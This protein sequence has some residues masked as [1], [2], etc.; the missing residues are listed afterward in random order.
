MRIRILNIAAAIAIA[1]VSG[2]AMAGKADDTLNVAF[3]EEVSTLDGYKEISRSGLIL[4][5]MLYDNLL[6]KDIKTGEFLPAL[7]E[8]YK[9]VDEKTL[10]FVIRKGV[11]FHD[12][13]ELTAD[14]VEYTLNQVSKKEYNTRY[15]ITVSWIDI[16]EKTGPYSV[17][18]R[19]K[20]VYPLA[21]E[22]LAGPLPIY[23]KHHL[24]AV[25]SSGMSAK[26]IGTG[27]YRLVESTTGTRFVLERFDEHYAG[28]PKGR[29]AIK[30]LVAKVLPE[31]NVQYAELMNGQLDWIWRVP[32]DASRRLASRPNLTVKAAPILRFA[33]M[34]MNPNFGGGKSPIADAKVRQAINHA[35][36]KDSII[37]ALV[38]GASESIAAACHPIAFACSKDVVKY[39]YDPK[40][41]KDLLAEAGYPNGFPLE[42]LTATTFPRSQVEAIAA[43]LNAV[44]IKTS[45][46]EQQSAVMRTNY[47]EGKAPTYLSS[48]GAYGIADAGLGTSPFFGG[49]GDDVVKDPQVVADLKIADTTLDRDVR[50]KHY[51]AAQKRVAEQAYWLPL[52]AFSVNT[53]QANNLSLDVDPDEFVPFYK[54]A[55]K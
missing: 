46:N 41:A 51:E 49:A 10:D 53:A 11:K 7:A 55:W 38:G 27:P 36:N 9:I 25:G 19:M 23:P 4:A 8:S 39:A 20:A 24:E 43:N 12:G 14:D 15:Q 26:P 29:P 17:R 30:R 31:A 54:A 6:M 34:G 32:H 44:G 28:S 22:M 1:T 42:L 50:K 47:I 35:V 48:W 2:Q 18:I 5:R 45:I 40:K 21:L 52:W 33:F 37:T 13:K 16:V 3:E